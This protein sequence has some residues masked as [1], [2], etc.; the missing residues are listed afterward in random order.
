MF[1]FEPLITFKAAAIRNLVVISVTVTINTWK[2]LARIS[3]RLKLTITACKTV[4]TVASGAT[5]QQITVPAIQALVRATRGW[6][7]W[8][9]TVSSAEPSWAI[10]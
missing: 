2:A 7:V 9:F 8:S 10:A 1:I 5:L 4:E 3:W 6:L